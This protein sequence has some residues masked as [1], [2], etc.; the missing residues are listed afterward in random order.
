V[1]IEQGI[2]KNDGFLHQDEESP[3]TEYILN[4]KNVWPE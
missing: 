3:E 1:L 2:L 4:F